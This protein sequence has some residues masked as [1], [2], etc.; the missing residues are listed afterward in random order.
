MDKAQTP[1]RATEVGQ[2][3]IVVGETGVNG[4]LDKG[5]SRLLPK[6]K[7]LISIHNWQHP[8]HGVGVSAQN[9]PRHQ[10]QDMIPHRSREHRRKGTQNRQSHIGKRRHCLSSLSRKRSPLRLLCYE[11][12]FPASLK[13]AKVELKTDAEI[14]QYLIETKDLTPC[15]DRRVIAVGKPKKVALIA[16]MRKL[17]TILNGMID[18]RTPVEGPSRTIF[19][20]L[21]TELA[22][23]CPFMPFLPSSLRFG[24]EA[25]F[26]RRSRRNL[27]FDGA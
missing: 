8:R 10:H 15:P 19:V 3:V 2:A 12:N 23:L 16:C 7:N 17:L 5:E 18:R 13:K 24:K 11:G 1:G 25:V 4:G 14:S 9:R 27:D 6:R 21:R 20:T 26:P 22:G